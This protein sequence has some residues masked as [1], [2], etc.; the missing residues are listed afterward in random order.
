[1]WRPKSWK[2]YK[3]TIY[4][5]YNTSAEIYEA[6]ADAMLKALPER[7]LGYLKSLLKLNP[8]ASLAS[9][10]EMIEI[11]RPAEYEAPAD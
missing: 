6:G 5:A 8:W 7:Q 10:I 2:P 4:N 9:T 1:M 3:R 11:T